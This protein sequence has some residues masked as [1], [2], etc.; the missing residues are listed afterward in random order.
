M[1]VCIA[2]TLFLLCCLVFSF[3]VYIARKNVYL[4]KSTQPYMFA[5]KM[6]YFGGILLT[7][8]K[9]HWI[10]LDVYWQVRGFSKV[11]MSFELIWQVLF[12]ATKREWKCTN[13]VFVIECVPCVV[14]LIFFHATSHTIKVKVKPQLYTYTYFEKKMLWNMGFGKTPRCG[15][16]D[17]E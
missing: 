2:G 6:K 14:L 8:K 16:G 11:F 9:I 13:H 1:S 5:L 10:V 3:V 7:Y 17:S 15:K 12:S 4:L